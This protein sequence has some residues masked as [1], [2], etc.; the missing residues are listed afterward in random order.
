MRELFICPSGWKLVG[1][2]SKGNQARGLAHYLGDEEFIDIILNKDVHIYNAGKL[3]D[4]LNEMEVEHDFT[5]ETL[6]PKAKRILYAFLFGASGKKLWSYIF[7]TPSVQQ[8]NKLK[9]GFIKAVPGFKDLVD[10]LEKIY[11]S[12][13]KNGYGYIP[14]LAGNRIYVDSFHKLLVY[15]LQACEKITCATA[16]MLTMEELERAEIPY[17]PLIMMHDEEDFMVPEEHSE[18]AKEIGVKSFKEG[19]ELYDITIMGGD[20]KVGDTWYDIH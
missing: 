11:G 2:D 10:K 8:G 6:R 12:T 16:V 7:G 17:V 1:C 3:I 15:L 19:A 18:R 13:S 14:S 5:P 4:V 20:G 9:K